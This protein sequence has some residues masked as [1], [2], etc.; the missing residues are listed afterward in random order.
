MILGCLI[1][2]YKS[3]KKLQYI[4]FIK[5]EEEAYTAILGKNGVGKSA[6]LEA[7]NFLL[8]YQVTKISWNMNKDRKSSK[9]AYVV[10]L[11]AIKKSN[12]EKYLAEKYPVQKQEILTIF[13]EVDQRIRSSKANKGFTNDEVIRFTRDANNY[14]DVDSFLCVSGRVFT[15]E[16]GVSPLKTRLFDQDKFSDIQKIYFEVV[17]DYHE[18]IYIP[19]EEVPEELL[20]LTELDIQ[21]VLNVKVYDEVKRILNSKIGSNAVIDQVNIQLSNYLKTINQSL[22]SNGNT[23]QFDTS[24]RKK[25]L[26][27]QDFVDRIIASYFSPRKLF[28][29]KKAKIPIEQLSSGEQKQAIINVFCALLD[30]QQVDQGYK[31]AIIFALDEPEISQDYSN[32]FPQ[33]ERLEGLARNSSFQVMLT[34]HWYGILPAA[35]GGT[36][37]LIDDKGESRSHEFYDIYSSHMEDLTEM[38]FKSVYDLVTSTVAFVRAYPKKRVIICEGPTDRLYLENYLNLNEVKIIP[39]GGRKNVI[40]TAQLLIVALNSVNLTGSVPHVLCVIDTDQELNPDIFLD[41]KSSEVSLC[42]WQLVNNSEKI[43]LISLI[44]IKEGGEKYSRTVIEDVL[45][46]KIFGSVVEELVNE[47]NPEY[48]EDLKLNVLNVGSQVVGTE[49]TLFNITGSK[50]QSNQANIE[51]LI[52]DNKGRLAHMYSKRFESQKL[53]DSYPIVVALSDAFGCDKKNIIKKATRIPVNRVLPFSSE[54][55]LYNIETISKNQNILK[56]GSLIKKR[57]NSLNQ[58]LSG[59]RDS[60]SSK[61]EETDKGTLKVLED[62]R[63]NLPLNE[64]VRFSEGYMIREK[65]VD[66]LIQVA[67]QKDSLD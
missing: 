18:Y 12:V 42:R 43:K 9:N 44:N 21:K 65:S 25:K 5:D 6:I 19:A 4:S 55:V 45:D 24:S 10:G 67:R 40:L 51:K 35:Y 16:T 62:I 23:Y 49:K 59:L 60:V 30:N 13:Q 56:K 3:F 22:E 29:V 33:F 58:T 8:N 64:T 28:K 14:N 37:L 46:S 2:G 15:G 50:G 26:Y 36:L 57:K 41:G 1:D 38:K 17:L 47:K 39:V 52:N 32:V 66:K 48:M 27:T 31:D 54:S 20:N 34:T 7:L 63:L 61:F 11:F 53:S